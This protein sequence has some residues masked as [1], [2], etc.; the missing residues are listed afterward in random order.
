[1]VGRK[2]D[3]GGQAHAPGTSVLGREA[4]EDLASV[5]PW[6]QLYSV[7]H[8]CMFVSGGLQA[9]YQEGLQPPRFLIVLSSDQGGPIRPAR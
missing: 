4:P 1:M 9:T 2:G 8:V 3:T 6:G 5:A 7:P